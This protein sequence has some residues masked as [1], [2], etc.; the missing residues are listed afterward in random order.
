MNRTLEKRILIFA[1]LVLTLTI[2]VNTGFNIEGFRRDYR[3]GI[4]LRCQSLSVGLQNAIENVLALGLGLQDMEGINLRC[5]EI[6]ATDPEIIYCLIEDVVGTPLYSSDPSFHFTAGVEFVSSL[7]KNTSILNFPHLGRTYDVSQPIHDADG[8]LAGRIRIGFP[9]SILEARTAKVFQRSMVI[10]GIAFFVVFGLVVVF[11]KRDLIGPIGRLC[12]V[13]KSIAAGD[14]KVTAPVMSTRDFAELATALQD[15]ASSL[16]SRDDKIGE[17]YRELEETNLQLLESYEYQ[18]RIGAELGRSREMYRSLLED[19]SDAIVV[20]DENDQIVLINKAAE[21]FFG[22]TFDKIEG[23]NLF[24][25]LEMLQSDNIEDQYG[26]HRA[27]LEGGTAETEVS[28]VRPS[29]QRQVIGWIVG[30]PVVGKDGNAW[31]RP[32]SVTSPKRRKSR[33]TS[34]RAPGNSSASTR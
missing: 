11:V 1:F 17:N 31:C 20:S 21:S 16:Q 30:S 9:E 26:L 12:S 28:F 32:P 10:L 25:A 24:S 8:K 7:S 5:Q 34:N 15:M 6:V 3:D 19:A 29:D 27:V 22:I 4:I 2:A 14:F 23:M 13:A 33:K 18:E